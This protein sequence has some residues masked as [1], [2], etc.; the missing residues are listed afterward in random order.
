[1]KS[2]DKKIALHISCK[3]IFN[4]NYTVGVDGFEPPTLCLKGRCSEPAELNARTVPFQKLCK[5]TAYFE[6]T[7][8]FAIYFASFF[9]HSTDC[10]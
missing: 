5:G 7:K 3:A 9:S 8:T 2:Q 1:M 6:T 10:Y 4:K